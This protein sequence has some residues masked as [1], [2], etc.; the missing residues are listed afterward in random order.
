MHK[1]DEKDNVFFDRRLYRCAKPP[2]SYLK[3]NV[4]QSNGGIGY[5]IQ[6][7]DGSRYLVVL[8]HM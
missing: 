5:L 7:D 8:V 6:N 3:V 1:Y 4:E 2:K